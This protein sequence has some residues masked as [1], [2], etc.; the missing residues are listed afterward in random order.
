M[1]LE[2]TPV[3]IS[4]PLDS[5]RAHN[6][7]KQLRA[8]H[9]FDYYSTFS[10][11][12]YRLRRLP[13]IDSERIRRRHRPDVICFN[14]NEVADTLRAGVELVWNAALTGAAVFTV[15]GSCRIKFK[16]GVFGL[17]FYKEGDFRSFN[18]MGNSLPL[19][20]AN[21]LLSL[22]QTGLVLEQGNGSAFRAAAGAENLTDGSMRLAGFGGCVATAPKEGTISFEGMR[23]SEADAMLFAFEKAGARLVGSHDPLWCSVKVA[24]YSGAQEDIQRMYRGPYTMHDVCPFEGGVLVSDLVEDARPDTF[25]PGG[26]LDI[27]GT[28]YGYHVDFIKGARSWHLMATCN[29]TV[30]PAKVERL[31]AETAKFLGIPDLF[32][33]E[34]S[35]GEEDY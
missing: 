11:W 30:K 13:L 2:L 3:G 27:C 23:N 6:I 32:P 22:A 19:E 24:N 35:S 8:C 26:A 10:R 14:T 29:G 4:S 21:V 33:V 1:T 34:S 9:R 15:G 20:K 18:L 5:L 17:G 7:V 28:G 25:V 31:R 16:R 12:P